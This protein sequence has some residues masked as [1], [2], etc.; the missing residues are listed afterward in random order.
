MQ[1]SPAHPKAAVASA[2]TD[3]GMS[4]SGMTTM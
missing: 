3:L 4:A 2:S 1:R